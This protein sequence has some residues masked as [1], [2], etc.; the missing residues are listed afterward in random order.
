M[1]PAPAVE[2]RKHARYP[3]T[4]G[5]QFYHEPSQRDLPARCADISEGGMKMYVPAATPIKPGD[6]V[7]L[8]LGALGRPEFARLG[9]KPLSA[10]IVR[11]DRQA[12]LEGG[13]LAVG[14]RFMGA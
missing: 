9:D 11:V 10:S 14:V 6:S 8:T 5:V 7:Y 12:L 2:R 13:H 3:L 4:T 1:C